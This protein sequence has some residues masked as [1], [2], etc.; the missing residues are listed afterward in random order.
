MPVP[1]RKI[2]FKP[3]RRKINLRLDVQWPGVF[4]N[5]ARAYVRKNYWK[6]AEHFRTPEDALGECALIWVRCL[7]KYEY[8]VNNPA[9]F[10]S[11]YKTAV[12]NDFVTYAHASSRSVV[13]YARNDED[14]LVQE[15]EQD[16]DFNNGYW[17]VLLS[18]ASDELKRI[19]E[20]LVQSDDAAL[21]KLLHDDIVRMNE[22]WRRRLGLR[23]QKDLVKE[24]QDLL[25]H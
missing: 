25:S 21:A 1:R 10:M 14:A 2:K 18:E 4:E 5:W 23:R 20:I 15:L 19:M 12:F 3:V 24:L 7:R 13:V 22:T 17:S 9:W 6:V 11:L 8:T 16:Q